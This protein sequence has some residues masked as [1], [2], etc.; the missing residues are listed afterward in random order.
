LAARWTSLA[1]AC[2]IRRWWRG[3]GRRAEAGG[4]DDGFQGRPP[5]AEQGGSRL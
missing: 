3:R 5:K 1:A 2:R 4:Y